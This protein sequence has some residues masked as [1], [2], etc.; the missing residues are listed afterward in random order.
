MS[1]RRGSH[2][3]GRPD[4]WAP[5][6]RRDDLLACAGMLAALVGVPFALWLF[7]QGLAYLRTIGIV[8]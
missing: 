7:S 8:L 1:R 5:A 2:V 6:T 3:P 4:P